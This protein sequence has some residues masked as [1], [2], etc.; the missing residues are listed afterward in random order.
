M[1]LAAIS[2][3]ISHPFLATVGRNAAIYRNEGNNVNSSS[4]CLAVALEETHLYIDL[5]QRINTPN[6]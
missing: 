6:N 2:V 3:I 4:A 1:S 5:P